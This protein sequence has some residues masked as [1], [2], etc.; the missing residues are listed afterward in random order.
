MHVAA[1]LERRGWDALCAPEGARRFYEEVL[2]D[3]V[4]MLFPGGTRVEGRAAVLD[5]MGGPPWAWY[6]LEDVAVREL[7]AAAAIVTYGVTAQRPGSEPYNA[8]CSSAYRR[9]A[10]GAWRLVVHQQTPA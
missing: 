4:V 1:D 3:D 8:L 9:D 7:G 5:S 2:A 10:A 6:R